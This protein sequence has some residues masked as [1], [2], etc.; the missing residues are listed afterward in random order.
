ML[1]DCPCITLLEM[2]LLPALLDLLFCVFTLACYADFYT[3]AEYHPRQKNHS[4]T[5]NIWEQ[6]CFYQLPLVTTLQSA[7]FSLTE[8]LLYQS[9]DTHSSALKALSLQYPPSRFLLFFLWLGTNRLMIGSVHWNATRSNT[10]FLLS[11]LGVSPVAMPTPML[12]MGVS[13]PWVSWREAAPFVMFSC[14]LAFSQ[15][16]TGGEDTTQSYDTTVISLLC[17]YKIPSSTFS[18]VMTNLLFRQWHQ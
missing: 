6:H 13:K 1:R 14:S 5:L 15:T 16:V 4:A 12:P 2:I 11:F 9:V 10:G 7:Q 3:S 8:A 17:I 18:A